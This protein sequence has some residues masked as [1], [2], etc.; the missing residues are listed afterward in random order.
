MTSLP[1]FWNLLE[2]RRSKVDEVFREMWKA[3]ETEVRKTKVVKIERMRK[4]RGRRKETEEERKEEETTKERKD[5]RG[6]KDSRRMR[7]LEW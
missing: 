3:M 4:E 6:K 5:N 7:D 1:Q 2:D